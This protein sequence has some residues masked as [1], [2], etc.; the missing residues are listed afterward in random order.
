MKKRSFVINAAVMT[1]TSLLL[2]SLAMV[3]RVYQSNKIGAEGIG[4]FQ[5]VLSV[6][7]L[8]TNFAISGLN[9]AVTRLVSEKMAGGNRYAVKRIMRKC[10]ALCL[11]FGL[12][13][14][15]LLFLFAPPI[16]TFWLGDERT[17]L[18]LRVLAVGLPFFSVSCCIRG[19]FLAA[20][21]SLK[22]SSGQVFEQLVNIGV[23][24]GTIAFF[25]SKGLEYAC[26]GIAVGM[27]A[28]EICACLYIY[29]VYRL[30]MRKKFRAE[31]GAG[32]PLRKVL[33]I[34]LPISASSCLRSALSAVENVL[35]PAGLKKH[36]AS[37]E[38]S[39]SSY[40]MLKGMVMP[41]LTFP[42]AFLS[43]FSMLLIPEM[44]EARAKGN[45]KQ[46]GYL[47]GRVFHTALLFAIPVTGLFLFFAEDFGMALYQS[48]DVGVYIRLLAPL[49]PFMYL[50]TIVDAM[51]KGLDEQVY[52]M[53]VNAV[54]STTRVV[55]I[56]VLLPLLGMKGYLMVTF[57]S[58][59]FNS[60]LS[61]FRLMRVGS[62]KLKVADRLIK[63]ALSI[64]AAC[65]TTGFLLS[66]G[67][68]AAFT[69]GLRVA[70]EIGCCA[71]F[72]LF[73]LRLCRGLKREDLDWVRRIFH[74]SGKPESSLQ[75]MTT[76]KTGGMNE[77]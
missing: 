30:E 5:L 43:A 11:T 69:P 57:F 70:C 27:T 40:G 32:A 33:G 34:A 65:L 49:I 35:I 62:L 41:V 50:D 72:Y 66:S 39:L 18:S 44:S 16:G 53:K 77:P 74:R 20:R 15:V 7:F 59:L 63:P 64:A 68:A 26:C 37:Y 24:M 22:P 29:V 36:G 76:R 56:F 10:F 54:D 28:G 42:A 3:F 48:A 17:V 9:F 25:L 52:Y 46:I 67:S 75:V 60:S 4:L 23:V 61:I 51:L 58:T 8:F 1:A 19:Y 21:N 31:Q 13:T 14:G 55:L 47:A 71:A 6:Y 38:S 73:F 12:A 2:S 45:H